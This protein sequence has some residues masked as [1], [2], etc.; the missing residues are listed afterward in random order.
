VG[1][2]GV[3]KA[4]LAEQLALGAQMA[5]RIDE[6]VTALDRAAEYRSDPYDRARDLAQ[7]SMLRW[8]L[9]R[10]GEARRGLDAARELLAPLPPSAAHIHVTEI[11]LLQSGRRG[12]RARRNRALAEMERLAA[13]T[14]STR[15]RGVVEYGRVAHDIDDG[16]LD[17]ALARLPRLQELAGGDADPL[18]T[19]RVMRPTAQARMC[20]G[21]PVAA[22]VAAQ[23]GVRLAGIVG[24]P[25]LACLHLAS[26][27]YVE[28]FCGRY[29]R[30]LELADQ[31]VEIAERSQMHRG[32]AFGLSAR[33]IA[34]VRQER[35]AEAAE[36]LAAVERRFGA[37]EDAD[38]H[39]FG[40][41]DI[42]R[43]LLALQQGRPA[44]A[45]RLGAVAVER[46][47]A[48]GVFAL[49]AHGLALV[50][51]GRTAQAR[52][53]A[54]QLAV[55]RPQDGLRSALAVRL[56]AR[57]ARAEDDVAAA[58][59]LGLRAAGAFE[60]LGIRADAAVERLAAA[61]LRAANGGGEDLAAEVE[62]L[63]AVLEGCG[64][65]A[66][67]DRCRRLL[68]ALGRRP[69]AAARG[70]GPGELS[71]RELEVVR[72]VA[73]GRSNAEVAA[74]LFIS[75][76]TVTTHLQ[77]V[78]ARLGVGSRTALAR[79]VVETDAGSDT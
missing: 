38:R 32:V 4:H 76:R 63:L 78:Y 60:G 54:A 44:E 49:D 33:M 42:A 24:V 53:I 37:W 48:L 19:E 9:G 29:Q 67:A 14:G 71:P 21:D 15:A 46:A 50:A 43:T 31:A 64:R 65:R 2:V 70:R 3:A 77:N 62:A 45:V 68:R 6:A 56:R 73:E 25:T 20:Q 30:S 18:F 55:D 7:A 8:D 27:S 51:D 66:S 57:I 23:E 13:A 69:A 10:F 74:A 52:E 36:V 12:D 75:Q 16:A 39:V 35:T 22:A 5:G 72:L 61:E 59:T 79:W 11:D 40:V 34:L 1:D 41:V 58:V 17:A 26:L 28:S 47:L